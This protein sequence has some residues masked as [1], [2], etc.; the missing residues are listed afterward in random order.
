MNS[1]PPVIPPPPIVCRHRNGEV[2]DP[3]APCQG[4]SQAVHLLHLATSWL[5]VL[6]YLDMTTSFVMRFLALISNLYSSFDFLWGS[7][8]LMPGLPMETIQTSFPSLEC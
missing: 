3:G 8:P 4:P 7:S 5:L 1:F 2:K 6:T